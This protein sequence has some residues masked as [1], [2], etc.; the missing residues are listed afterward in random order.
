MVN[1][2]DI[3]CVTVGV[4]FDLPSSDLRMLKEK[5]EEL[6]DFK[7]MIFVGERA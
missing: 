4:F 2:E 7:C 1:V 5:I 6:E 3:G